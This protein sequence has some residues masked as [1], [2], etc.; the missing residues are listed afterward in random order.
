MLRR[1][2]TKLPSRDALDKGATRLASQPV[3]YA[4]AGS[5]AFSGRT[6]SAPSSRAASC[7]G[8]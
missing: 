7:D 6:G 3:C 1:D 5:G 8:M 2:A 4:L